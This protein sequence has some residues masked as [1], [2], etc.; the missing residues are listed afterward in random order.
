MRAGTRPAETSGEGG[1]AHGAGTPMSFWERWS[2]HVTAWLV[3]A[4]GLV[5]LWM[6]YFA[7]SGDPFAVVNHP[8]QPA[9]LKIHLLSAPFFILVFGIVFQSHVTRKLRSRQTANRRSG[10]VSL[11]TFAL[12][13]M[14]GYLLQVVSTTAAL[15]AALILHLASSGVF[16][17]AYGAH[18]VIS[19]RLLRAYRK[20]RAE[21][22]ALP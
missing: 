18:L 5:Y 10:W 13:T 14:S 9:M 7:D 1:G 15:R 22:P 21:I 4:S 20:A 11:V 8:W 17:A 6:K 19:V 3:A 2:L 16:M 12:M